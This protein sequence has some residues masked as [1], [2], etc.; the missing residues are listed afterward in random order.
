MEGV[1]PAVEPA[2]VGSGLGEGRGG[3]EGEGSRRRGPRPRAEGVAQRDGGRGGHPGGRGGRGCHR[4]HVWKRGQRME[5]RSTNR[6]SRFLLYL[7]LVKQPD[8]TRVDLLLRCRSENNSTV[9][10]TSVPTPT[11][12]S[13]LPSASDND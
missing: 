1:D 10:L 5:T 7:T 4:R 6:N 2:P 8:V 11:P 13:Q 3:W 12:V 9:L